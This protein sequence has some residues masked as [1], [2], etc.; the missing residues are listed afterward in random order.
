MTVII[1]RLRAVQLARRRRRRCP[2]RRCTRRRRRRG[3]PSFLAFI[4]HLTP[5]RGRW[6]TLVF[7]RLDITMLLILSFLLATVLAA[8]AASVTVSYPLDDQLPPIAR[9]NTP[10]SWTFSQNTFSSDSDLTYSAS[11]LPAWLSFDPSTRTLSGT[12]GPGD[13]GSPMITIKASAS[14]QSA[15]SPLD[16]CV[17]HYPPPELR[18]PVESQFHSD[19]PSLSSVFIV[20]NS[21]SLHRGRPTLRIPSKWSFSIGF[22]YKTF[23]ANNSLYYSPSQADGS[24]L[25]DWVDFN[26][27]AMTFNGYA[28][29]PGFSDTPLSHTL[30]LTLHASDQ[31]GPGVRVF[32]RNP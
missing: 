22:N 23:A 8:A 31:Q 26:A 7:L 2:P 9:V 15:S 6:S 12:P 1:W 11:A 5:S 29:A 32:G 30:S 16:L 18:I 13:E 20:S 14:G 3:V 24:P 17:T 28:P 4:S 25:P 27:H 10:F 19:N 21:S